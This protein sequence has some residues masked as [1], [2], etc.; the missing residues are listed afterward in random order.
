MQ[1]F[2]C[3]NSTVFKLMAQYG[4]GD[5]QRRYL[6]D[7]LGPLIQEKIISDSELELVVNPLEVCRFALILWLKLSRHRTD[8]P[9]L[10]QFGRAADRSRQSTRIEPIVSASHWGRGD[11]NHLH[12]ACVPFAAHSSNLSQTIELQTLRKLTND[13]TVKIFSSSNRMP[14]GMRYMAREIYRGLRVSGCYPLCCTSIS[15]WLAGEVPA[16]TRRR[17]LASCRPSHLLQVHESSSD[18]RSSTSTGDVC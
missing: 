9:S 4:R 15:E 7:L 17:R 11:E 10:R 2:L 6:V 14:F 12:T 16:R 1:E 13:F 3:A 8:L 18:V 5:K